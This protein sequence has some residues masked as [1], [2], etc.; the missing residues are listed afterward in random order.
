VCRLQVVF[1]DGDVCDVDNLDCF[2][3]LVQHL[4]FVLALLHLEDG[5]LPQ[6]VLDH[7]LTVLHSVF[8]GLQ[9]VDQDLPLF[10]ELQ[11]ASVEQALHF[12]HLPADHSNLVAV[13]QMENKAEVEDI[14]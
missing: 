4:V 13:L 6:L 11:V 2:E 14:D 1:L 8:D 10:E 5:N 12:F 3:S 9:H 7:L